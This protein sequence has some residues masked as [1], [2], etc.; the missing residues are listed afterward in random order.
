MDSSKTVNKV[1]LVLVR[2]F[3]WPNWK[4]ICRKLMLPYTVVNEKAKN[5]YIL[6]VL[7]VIKL[8]LFSII[9]IILSIK[10][11]NWLFENFYKME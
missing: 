9:S 2:A 3:R 7:W 1:Y 4:K 6:A 11:L 8:E 5:S 10:L